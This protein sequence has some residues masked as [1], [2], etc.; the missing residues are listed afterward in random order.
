MSPQR[1]GSCS[2][3]KVLIRAMGAPVGGS[4]CEAWRAHGVFTRLLYCGRVLGPPFRAHLL[5]P[6][7]RRGAL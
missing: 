1:R 3:P 6:P 7:A 4:P 5:R 2:T